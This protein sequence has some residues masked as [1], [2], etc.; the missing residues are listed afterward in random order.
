MN[1]SVSSEAGGNTKPPHKKQIA[2]SIRWIMTLNNYTE[3]ELLHISTIV[4][5]FCKY[6][7]IGKEVGEETETPHLQGYIEFKHKSRPCSVFNKTD[8]IRWK[9]A[10]GTRAQ[11]IVYCAKECRWLEFPEEEEIEVIKYD[12]LR[13]WQ[14]EV[15]NI[16]KEKPTHRKIHWFYGSANI[17]KTEMIRYLGINYKVP[18][19]YGGSVNDIMNLAYNNLNNKCKA[20]IFSLTRKQRNKIDYTALE[21]LKDG[22]ISNNKY[23]TGTKII[24][25]PHVFVFANFPP[26]DD[27]EEI[28]MSNDKIIIYN[29]D[30]YG[31]D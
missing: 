14:L 12:Q 27:E 4:P 24:N 10:I 5:L 1:S 2:P 22:L 15:L 18:F 30:E 9:K 16:Y 6:A 28:N 25:R 13:K 11:N 29:C 26:E 31:W 23:E 19:S 7:V 20:F 3:D 17:G 8:R 21:Q